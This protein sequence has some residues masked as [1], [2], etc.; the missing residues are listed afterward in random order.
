MATHIGH[1]IMEGIIGH[2]LIK[3]ECAHDSSH[4]CVTVWSSG[5]AEQIEAMAV[6]SPHPEGPCF[7][8]GGEN[9]TWFA[10]NEIWNAVVRS[11][12]KPDVMLCPLCFIRRAERAGYNKDAWRIAPEFFSGKV[13]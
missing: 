2:N 6:Q 1:K 7:D 11:G 12:D 13:A 5:A 4:G 8:C 10:P 9:V 3:T